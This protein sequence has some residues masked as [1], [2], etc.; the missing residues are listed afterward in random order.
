[1]PPRLGREATHQR[2]VDQTADNRYGDDEPDAETGQMRV[3]RPARRAVLAVPGEQV[4]EAEDHVAK[5]DR[6]EARTGPGQQRQRHQPTAALRGRA[7][8]PGEPLLGERLFAFLDH[9]LRAY[10]TL[11]T[12]RPLC[13][14]P[15]EAQVRNLTKPIRHGPQ[16]GLRQCIHEPHSRQHAQT[17]AAY[18]TRIVAWRRPSRSNTGSEPWRSASPGRS[19]FP[20]ACGAAQI[21]RR[22]AMASACSCSTGC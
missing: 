1:M 8:Q 9:E 7:A 12:C 2:S 5:R 4:G 6:A 14:P 19:R 21:P 3:D 22:P 16:R 20:K 13:W 17:F 10:A 11:V 15:A 18:S